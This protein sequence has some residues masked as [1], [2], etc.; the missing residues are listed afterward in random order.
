MHE[1]T[2]AVFIGVVKNDT[3]K[4]CYP[5]YFII[6]FFGFYDYFLRRWDIMY[7]TTI[8]FYYIISKDCNRVNIFVK[9]WSRK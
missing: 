2:D 6:D 4:G 3:G 1:Y 9:S 5:E 7:L 8:V